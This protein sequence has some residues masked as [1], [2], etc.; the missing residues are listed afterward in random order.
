MF[1]LSSIP[2]CLSSTQ[3][4]CNLH[5]LCCPRIRNHW[6]SMFFCV[7][8]RND[9]N[10][11]V[12]VVLDSRMIQIPMSFCL[13]FRNDTICYVFLS[14]TQKRTNCNVS[15]DLPFRNDG[16]YAFLFSIQKRIKCNA[17]FVPDSEMHQMVFL[18]PVFRNAT[19]CFVICC[20]RL[21]NVLNCNVP[22]VLDS[23]M[24]SNAMNCNVLS[25][26]IQ[27]RNELYWRC[28]VFSSRWGSFCS[29]VTEYLESEWFV[30][31][32]CANRHHLPRHLPQSILVMMPK[33]CRSAPNMHI[34]RRKI[35]IG[36]PAAPVALGPQP[37][38]V[39][40]SAPFAT[41]FVAKHS[42]HNSQTVPIGTKH[43]Y[44]ACQGVE[45]RCRFS[46]TTTYHYQ[47]CLGEVSG[48]PGARWRLSASAT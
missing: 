19:N 7:R 37:T 31:Q 9:I 22:F 29:S 2:K 5:G 24:Q 21:R 25:S 43:A 14:S 3:K 41:A 48:C 38:K 30:L 6:N 45:A 36:A 17:S 44:S 34:L 33:L 4:H 11:N 13:R 18:F 1:I 27:I 47:V 46:G 40:R 39:C 20:P 15:V 32:K 42:D 12:V 16:L 23:E 28:N 26:P 35:S 10:H 8:F